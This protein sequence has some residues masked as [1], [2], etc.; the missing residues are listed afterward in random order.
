M[1]GEI[2]IC[3]FGLW[4][5]DATRGHG[6]VEGGY[7]FHQAKKKKKRKSDLAQTFT[8]LACQGDPTHLHSPVEEEEEEEKEVVSTG[9]GCFSLQ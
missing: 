5:G 1:R 2:Y 7:N 3:P 6:E 4:K 9:S 8:F